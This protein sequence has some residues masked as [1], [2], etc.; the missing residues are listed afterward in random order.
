MSNFPTGFR[1][2]LS[3]LGIFL[4][5][6]TLRAQEAAPENS[7][8][9]KP[10][11]TATEAA[12]LRQEL[13]A[14]RR[15]DA[16]NRHKL[17]Q[18]EKQMSELLQKQR[19]SLG[20]ETRESPQD[21]LERTLREIK[22]TEAESTHASTDLYSKPI[23]AAS[24]R[25]FD[26]FLA[27]D[28]AAGTSSVADNELSGLQA[29]EHDPNKRG[30][31]V[32]EVELGFKAAIDPYFTAE[33]YM[34]WFIDAEGESILEL[35]EAFATT[36]QLP[37]GFQM[38]AGHIY[39]EFGR[40]NSQ[41]V[42]QWDWLDQP[43]I[44]TRLMGPA[45][46]RAPGARLGWLS[47][48]PWYSEF[49]VGMQNASGETMASFLSD[50]EV[51]EGMFPDRPWVDQDSR[52]LADFVYL[53]RWVNGF[54]VTNT[55]SGIVG[56]SGTVGPNATGTDGR[57]TIGGADLFFRWRPLEND[58]GWPFV[59]WQSEFLWRKLFADGTVD[60]ASEGEIPSERI[61]D[62]GLYTQALY[63][64]VQNWAGG[65]RFEHG[66]GSHGENRQEN[67]F[68]DDR[69]RISPLL[70]WYTSEFARVRF[71]FNYDNAAFLP[72]RHA[73]TAWVGLEFILGS[74][75]AHTF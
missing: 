73:Y 28:V 39:T 53:L 19:D 16:E 6:N 18:L 34:I 67:P 10:S 30:F 65:L 59:T 31:T 43:V 1:C 15:N 2:A 49:L 38:T 4:F 72:D 61:F 21:A 40:L 51:F 68:R 12:K 13:E 71:Q 7:L 48:L 32:Q 25:L 69:F 5:L 52:T 55:I 41:H 33:A 37:W 58:R 45:G 17:R 64:F 62:Y 63:G 29:G 14:L 56:A 50:R 27:S 9:K 57:T 75:S 54:D 74:H 3:V 24:F 46:M 20:A 11:N 35:E 42:H 23:G 70:V 8:Q 36:Q 66:T 47:P 26:L 22:V 60:P 44:T